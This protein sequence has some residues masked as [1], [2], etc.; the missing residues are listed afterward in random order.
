MPTLMPKKPSNSAPCMKRRPPSSSPTHGTPA[1]PV[2]SPHSASRPSPP[3]AEHA[4]VCLADWTAWSPATKPWRI[5]K[6]S[7]RRPTCRFPPIWRKV[8]AI[9]RGAAADC[10]RMAAA[11]RARRSLDRGRHVAIPARPLFDPTHA[12]ERIAAA[13][14]AAHAP[15]PFPFTLTAR[16]ENF[17]RNNPDLDDTIRRLKSFE[18]AGA[19]VLMAPGSARPGHRFARCAPRSHARSISWPGSKA[20]RSPWRPCPQSGQTRQPRDLAVPRRDD[21]TGECRAGGRRR[22]NVRLPG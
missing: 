8:L 10:I 6:P 12:E 18:A 7:S 22:R 9:P 13:A 21:R 17:L 16:T 15:V 20:S 1:P 2:S 11:N 4:P 19:E 3:P 5:A 14:E